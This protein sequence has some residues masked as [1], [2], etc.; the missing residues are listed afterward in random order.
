MPKTLKIELSEDEQNQ[1]F[2]SLIERFD[3]E[4]A[5]KQEI[6]FVITEEVTV[7]AELS[8]DIEYFEKDENNQ[9]SMCD[10]S[11]SFKIWFMID[12]EEIEVKDWNIED[13]INDHYRI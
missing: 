5:T 8:L 6:E 3:P 12:G 7:Y 2:D 11:A 4:V 9:T 10:R 1:I 13:R